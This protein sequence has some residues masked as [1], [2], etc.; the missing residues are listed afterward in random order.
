VQPATTEY[1]DHQARRDVEV[2]RLAGLF[3]WLVQ[4][5]FA[6]PCDPRA[7][8]AAEVTLPLFVHRRRVS[9][10]IAISQQ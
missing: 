5:L 7:A 2:K 6:P 10:A 9:V 1:P 4:P 8:N 3:V